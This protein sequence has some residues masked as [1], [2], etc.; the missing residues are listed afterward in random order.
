MSFFSKLFKKAITPVPVPPRTP[1]IEFKNGSNRL[2]SEY[3][4]LSSKN[5]ALKL[6]IDDLAF[7][8]KDNLNKTLVITMIYR[9]QEEQDGLYKNDPKYQIRK[10]KSPHQFWH[11][12]DIRSLIFTDLEIKQIEDY[13]NKKYNPTNYYNW[14]ARNHKISGQQFHFHIQFSSK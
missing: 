11:S 12:V 14:T 2:K 7:F 3:D 13:L 10:F 6:L 9:T 1:P 8:I 4:T 5:Q